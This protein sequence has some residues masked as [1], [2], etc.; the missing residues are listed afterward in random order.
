[1][2]AILEIFILS[3]V[4]YLIYAM[5][6]GRNVSYAI[7]RRYLLISIS[8]AGLIPFVE[9]PVEVS[10]AQEIYQVLH[11]NAG[12]VENYSNIYSWIYCAG[13]LFMGGVFFSQLYAIRRK[14]N[15]GVTS[16]YNYKGAQ[17]LECARN[18]GDEFSF[19]GKIAISNRL[20]A[21]EKSLILEHELSHVKHN[22][23]L[24]KVFMGFLKIVMWFNPFV[25]IAAIHIEELQEYEA[26]YDV[27]ASGADKKEY[28]ALIVEQVITSALPVSSKFYSYF[29]KSRFNWMLNPPRNRK[30]IAVVPF[31]ICV[32]VMVF[33]ALQANC[34]VPRTE[35]TIPHVGTDAD[36]LEHA[37]T[38]HLYIPDNEKFNTNKIQSV[39]EPDEQV[40]IIV[41]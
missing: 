11:Y 17:V 26:D 14:I 39:P 5:F 32:A 34:L 20:S 37:G 31:A 30:G 15:E 10:V 6:M 38:M 27:L 35:I 33:S 2:D 7:R 41:N 23:S 29:T 25:Y 3:G 22:H 9:I 28:V 4:S 19:F 21:S 24:E 16:R 18:K 36:S 40:L 1:M 13:A 12:G 8:A